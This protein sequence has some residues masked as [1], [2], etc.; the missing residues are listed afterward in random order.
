M[1]VTTESLGVNSWYSIPC[2]PWFPVP[3]LLPLWY[4]YPLVS[5]SLPWVPSLLLHYTCTMTIQG[6][7]YGC[8]Y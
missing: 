1:E 2:Y 5:Y 7:Y 8:G 3:P 6:L 4:R